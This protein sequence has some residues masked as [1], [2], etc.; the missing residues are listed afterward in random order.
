MITN[1]MVEAALDAHERT[2]SSRR[3]MMRAA[4]DAVYPLIVR[5][6]AD[7]V[8]REVA[9]LPDRTS[10]EDYPDAM[11]VTGDELRG[12]ILALAEQKGG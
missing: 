11:L 10:P 8:A 6:I 3:G 7:R 1:E 9:E 4:L 2:A 5:S 12:I